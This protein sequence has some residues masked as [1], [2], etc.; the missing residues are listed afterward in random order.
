MKTL[1]RVVSLL[2]ILF[3]VGIVVVKF[4]PGGRYLRDYYRGGGFVEQYRRERADAKLRKWARKVLDKKQQD[5]EDRLALEILLIKAE[6]AILEE[7]IARNEKI[8]R[9]REGK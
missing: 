2:G 1:I 8:L 9:E 4:V 7:N 5:R 6:T 3:I